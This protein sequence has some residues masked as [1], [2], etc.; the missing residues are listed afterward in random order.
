M[1]VMS[2]HNSSIPLEKRKVE[3][4]VC[5]ELRIFAGA[6][7]VLVQLKTLGPD[8]GFEKAQ[9]LWK[10]QEDGVCGGTHTPA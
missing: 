8:T 5:L 6:G 2:W 9:G 3:I 4:C 7:M 10:E 1:G